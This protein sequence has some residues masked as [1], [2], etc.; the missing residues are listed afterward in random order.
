MAFSAKITLGDIMA[1]LL[2]MVGKHSLES[3]IAPQSTEYMKL[4]KGDSVEAII[5]SQK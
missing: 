3:V 2:V 1:D 4:K 5:K